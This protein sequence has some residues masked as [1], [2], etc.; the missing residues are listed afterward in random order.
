MHAVKLVVALYHRKLKCQ[1]YV[2][3]AYENIITKYMAKC[4]KDIIPRPK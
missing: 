4:T 1:L 3:V 2:H